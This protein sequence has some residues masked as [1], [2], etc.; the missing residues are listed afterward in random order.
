MM[1]NGCPDDH[2]NDTYSEHSK[3]LY[4]RSGEEVSDDPL[5]S[6][7]YDLMRDHVAPGIVE[8]IVINS[9]AKR[10]KFSNGYLAKYAK[11]LAYRL[12]KEVRL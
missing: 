4:L 2:E 12:Q 6:F 1:K 10:T 7:L 5:V 9:P 8:R 11:D 3:A